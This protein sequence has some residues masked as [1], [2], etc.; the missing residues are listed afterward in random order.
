MRIGIGNGNAKLSGDVGAAREMLE[1]RHR[2]AASSSITR[3]NS[4]L[5][6]EARIRICYEDCV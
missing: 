6:M 5:T 1:G 2:Y 3:S 4:I